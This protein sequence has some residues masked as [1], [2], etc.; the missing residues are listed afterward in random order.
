MSGVAL[1][2]IGVDVPVKFG[3]SRSN[4]SWDIRVALFVMDDEWRIKTTPADGLC[5]NRAALNKKLHS[6]F[7]IV[8]AVSIV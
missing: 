4:R 2:H 5:T 8:E 1:E 7:T 3:D 6:F